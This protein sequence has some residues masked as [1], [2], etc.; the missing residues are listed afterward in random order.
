MMLGLVGVNVGNTGQLGDDF[1]HTWVVLHGAR[2]QRIEPRVDAK[3]TLGKPRV[4]ANHFRLRK[5]G[6]TGGLLS[7]ETTWHGWF[8]LRL[9]R[10]RLA[11]SGIFSTVVIE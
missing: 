8:G 1:V 7:D 2:T 9:E 11:V 5:T 4:M 3:V 6:P 10:N